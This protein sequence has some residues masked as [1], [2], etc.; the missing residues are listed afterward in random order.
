M[1]IFVLIYLCVHTKACKDLYVFLTM[2]SQT[3]AF[4]KRKN[5]VKTKIHKRKNRDNNRIGT[6][7]PDYGWRNILDKKSSKTNRYHQCGKRKKATNRTKTK[8]EKPHRKSKAN[9]SNHMLQ[10]WKSFS[11]AQQR[12]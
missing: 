5:F 10:R 8:R 11:T 2:L 6:G 9:W 7:H 1:R 12:G 4:R 3:K